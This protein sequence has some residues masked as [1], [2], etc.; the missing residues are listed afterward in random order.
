VDAEHV[1]LRPIKPGEDDDLVT[2]LDSAEPL[3]QFGLEDEPGVGRAL[4]PLLWRRRWIG[5][6]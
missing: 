4:V 5:Q 2:G 1:A 6:R 3:D